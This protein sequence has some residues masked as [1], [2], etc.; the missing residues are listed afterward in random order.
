ME[1]LP[2]SVFI[3]SV[4]P[5][6][7]TTTLM[8]EG[9]RVS[10]A[11]RLAVH[12]VVLRR[13]KATAATCLGDSSELLQWDE[14]TMQAVG[15]DMHARKKAFVLLWG[16]AA[17]GGRWQ[18]R[19]EASSMV[20]ALRITMENQ[21]DSKQEHCRGCG[22]GPPFNWCWWQ[23]VRLLMLIAGFQG[24][25]QRGKLGVVVTLRADQC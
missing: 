5:F 21:R 25:V 20:R 3:H 9:R 6:I 1:R 24:G 10:R 22:C 8:D 12:S 19:Y 17:G 2:S 18:V 4:L 13:V 16:A 7:E 23:R 11:V 14:A 15:V